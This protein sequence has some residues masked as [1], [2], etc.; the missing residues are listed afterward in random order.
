MD[1]RFEEADDGPAMGRFQPVVGDNVNIY[2]LTLD[3]DIGL[4]P[5]AAIVTK[6]RPGR[7]VDVTVFPPG[8]EPWCMT[9]VPPQDRPGADHR[10]WTELPL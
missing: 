4:G 5:Y 7:V 1:T 6:L 8:R 10:Y 9:G 2:G 3:V